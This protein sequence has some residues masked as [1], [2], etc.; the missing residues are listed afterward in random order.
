MAQL[1]N[2]PASTMDVRPV[3]I[4][5]LAQLPGATMDDE[6]GLMHSD[7]WFHNAMHAAGWAH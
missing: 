7:G 4:A 6:F 5:N 2:Q 1:P 3:V